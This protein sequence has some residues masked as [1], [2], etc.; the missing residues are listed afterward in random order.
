MR[1]AVL[2]PLVA[3]FL[4]VAAPAQ[5]VET[6]PVE[7][8]SPDGSITRVQVPVQP[9]TRL[10]A[11]ETQALADTH[12]TALQNA[13]PSAN[14]ID[15]VILGD[16]YTADQQALF[17]EHA[18]AKWERIA[19][20][21]PFTEYA[22]YFNVWLVDVVSNESGV[23]NDP[24]PPAMRDTAL[25]GQFWCNGTERLLC[26][27]QA[28]ASAAAAAAPG[29][30]QILVLANSTKYGGA[31]GG[32]ATSSGGSAAAGLITVHEL[33]HSLGGL[34]DEYDY[35]YRAG[36]DED[37]T[38]DVTIPAPYAFYPG[39]VLG[40]PAGTN[41]TA[42][43]T[44]E[45]LVAQKLKWWRWVGEPSPEGGLVGTFEGAGYYRKGMYRPSQD[46]LM[47]TLGNS[48]GG[49][50]FN[51]PSAE[52]MVVHFYRKVRPISG[53]TAEGTAAPGTTLR[54]DTLQPATHMLDIRWFVDGR[55]LNAARGR[56]SLTVTQ[57]RADA[58]EN[59]S[60]TVADPTSFVR[61]PTYLSRELTQ[62]LSW[63]I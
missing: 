58:Y 34:A 50:P 41:I 9:Q 31:G 7:V 4:T 29:A 42:A 55:E 28:K 45:A 35:Y 13:G 53:G 62:T 15:L 33:G 63:T 43:A 12:V 44:P 46:S 54:I 39:A 37:S 30:D 25:D 10:S 52:E 61:N 32:V 27:N 40:E 57:A 3:V 59:I 26:V 5:A 18:V 38:Q 48:K 22:S 20:T 21:E 60:V 14:R 1:R 6:H 11:A 2:A 49:N 24:T 51:P 23:D 16:G 36:L 56:R 19:R 17:H 47:H 8:F